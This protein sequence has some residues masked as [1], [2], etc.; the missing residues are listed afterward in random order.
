MNRTIMRVAMLVAMGWCGVACGSVFQF[1][2]PVTVEKGEIHAFCWIPPEA[3][4][5]RGVIV[6]GMT[7][8]EQ[9]FAKDAQ[10]RAAC[11]DQQ[12]A[13]VFLTTGL[14]S[15]DLQK[16]LDDLAE[17][18][19][20]AELRVAPLFFVGH[21]AGGPQA[22]NLAMKYADR[23][24]GLIQYRGGGP[25]D[26]APV[27]AE[28]PSLMMVGAFDEFH[29]TMRNAEG[30][31]AWERYTELL[32]KHRAADESR[33][34]SIVVEPGAGHFAWSDRNAAIASMF[35]RKSAAG[36]IPRSWAIDSDA[37]PAMQKIDAATGWLS[38]VRL[39]Q[40]VAA[41]AIDRFTGDRAQASWWFDEEMARAVD[42]YHANGFGRRDQFIK[43]NDPTW[44]DAGVRHF[45]TQLKWIEDGATLKLSPVYAASFPRPADNGQGPRWAQAG[46]AVGNSGTPIKVRAVAGPLVAAGDDT[47]RLEYDALNPAGQPARGT[48]IAYSEG[49]DA[50]RYT[51]QIGMLPRGFRGLD[52]KEQ[53]ITFPP[54]EEAPFDGQP[55]A[56]HATSDSGLPVQYYVAVGPARVID[57]K[58]HLHERP[59]RARFPIM[60]EVVAYQP[61]S[62]VEPRFR[63]TG[64]T[65]QTI[66]LQQ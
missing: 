5:V 59:K 34:V 17:K 47:L 8:M 55:I 64:P 58:L 44:I 61:G 1:R 36:R 53:K 57:G 42:A 63:T 9:H 10:I 37:P 30:R 27:P 3:D 48:F 40:P 31:E 26:G 11:I 6:A 62:G 52:G 56:L 46:E 32:A 60:I 41:A 65:V 12:L 23:C 45:F 19:G 13:I 24:F 20:Y 4:Q 25:F 50:F 28:I 66:Q 18:S 43:W 22:K 14:E 16:V 7:L 33:L 51:E 54:I 39:K 15:T 21:S 29:G 49:N 38:D 2:V 35:I